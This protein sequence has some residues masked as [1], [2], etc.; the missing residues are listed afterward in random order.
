MAQTRVEVT[1]PRPVYEA[2]LKLQSLSRVAINYEDL[3]YDSANDVEDAS[4]WILTPQQRQDHPN[5]K[6]IIPKAGSLSATLP[7]DG[8]G[9]LPDVSTTEQALAAVLAAQSASNTPGTLHSEL[10]GG[11]LFVEP[12]EQ[13]SAQGFRVSAT[14]I[15]DTLVT[16]DGKEALAVDV[17]EYIVAQIRNASGAKLT[18]GTVPIG[19][20]LQSKVA[21]KANGESAK[22]VL[23]KLLAALFP[24][25]TAFYH[26]LYD[27]VL[28]VYV[29][30][31]AV[32]LE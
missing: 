26:A 8:A 2:I 31:V 12:S 14:P 24:G 20:F 27:P 9:K 10:A 1:A 5:A 30:N 6:V 25:R 32:K 11:V 13:H 17:F 15:L 4:G 7:T 22:F 18:L 21:L 16:L 19:A 28:Q 29:F 23:A 3:R